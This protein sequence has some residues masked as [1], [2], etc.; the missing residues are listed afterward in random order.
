MRI[1][2]IFFLQRYFYAPFVRVFMQNRVKLRYMAEMMLNFD[3]FM[4]KGEESVWKLRGG[5]IH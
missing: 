2:N 1:K 5:V 4:G 3:L